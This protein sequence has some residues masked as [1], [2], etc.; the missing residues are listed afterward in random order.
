MIT[1]FW[2]QLGSTNPIN[3]AST[4]FKTINIFSS[5]SVCRYDPGRYTVATSCPSQASGSDLIIIPLNVT[6]GGSASYFLIGTQCFLPLAYCSAL[7]VTSSFSVDKTNFPITPDSFF[8]VRF[9]CRLVWAFECCDV[10][11]AVSTTLFIHVLQ[12]YSSLLSDW[13]VVSRSS[14]ICVILL[15]H[16]SWAIVFFLQGLNSL[17]PLRNFSLWNLVWFLLVIC[18]YH[19]G[20]VSGYS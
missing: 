17:S 20:N 19:G 2:K 11:W 8:F 6:S 15:L 9:F 10:V 4:K 3:S 13:T 1:Y 18:F 14:P 5:V 12:I 7:I 16:T